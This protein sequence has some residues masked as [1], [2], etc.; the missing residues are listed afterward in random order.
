MMRRNL[1]ERAAALH[2]DAIVWDTHAGFSPF[3]DLDLGF[4]ARWR[5]AGATYLSVNVG[6]DQV[7]RW[8]ETLRCTA[9]FRRWLA[10]HPEEFALVE[11]VDD[12]RRAKATG[13]LAIGFDIEG[14][15]ALDEN[16]DMIALYYRLGVRQL[17]FAYNRNNAFGGGCHDTDMPLTELG[18]RAVR[19]MNRVG[20]VIDCSHTGHRTTMDIM[21]LSEKPVVF[22]HS[23]PRALCDHGR[24]IRD[25]QIKSCAAT[26]GV[27]GINGVGLFLGGNDTR[28]ETIVRHIDYVAQL[29]G[30]RHA[31]L[32]LDC[33]IDKEELPR[34]LQQYPHAWPGYTIGDMSGM[35]F[36]A[37]EQLP[38]ITEALLDRGYSDADV[39]GIIGENFLRVAGEVWR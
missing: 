1:P 12:I 21:Q 8:D 17:L 32:G 22:S 2:R 31:G 36:A 20:M 4:L 26:G 5:A 11:T 29:V 6:Y 14:A 37:P 7:M 13:R 35:A 16:I 18:R 10:L 3:P 30:A 33:V 38:E 27:V 34:L 24:N 25:D 9:H 28:S 39:R 19:E 23:N 15:N